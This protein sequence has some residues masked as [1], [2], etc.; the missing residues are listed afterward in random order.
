MDVLCGTLLW[1]QS[2]LPNPT[3]TLRVTQIVEAPRGRLVVLSQLQ[4]NNPLFFLSFAWS[5]VMHLDTEMRKRVNNASG[6]DL[7]VELCSSIEAVAVQV[8]PCVGSRC[9]THSVSELRMGSCRD[10]HHSMGTSH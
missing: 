4:T 7:R 8:V 10:T 2:L 9:E 1:H 5:S 3:Q 6:V